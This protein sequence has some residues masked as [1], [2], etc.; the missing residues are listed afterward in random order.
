MGVFCTQLHGPWRGAR[1]PSSTPNIGNFVHTSDGR[2][3]AHRRNVT[4]SNLPTSNSCHSSEKRLK[5]RKRNSLNSLREKNIRKN[6]FLAIFDQIATFH[7]LRLAFGGKLASTWG[8][9]V[10][11]ARERSRRRA[12]CRRGRQRGQGRGWDIPKHR[13]SDL[14]DI[15]E[16]SFFMTRT[17]FSMISW[18]SMTKDFA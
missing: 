7:L 13:R 3:D 4:P 16:K 12:Q 15:C 5:S 17:T 14:G 9:V 10:R 2:T 6:S 11:D 8:R 1:T 18:I